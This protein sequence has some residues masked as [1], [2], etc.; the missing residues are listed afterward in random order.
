[1][2]DRYFAARRAPSFRK[3]SRQDR[4]NGFS[5]RLIGKRCPGNAGGNIQW[6]I[7]RI[8]KT[9]GQNHPRFLRDKRGGA[10]IRMAA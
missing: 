9:V 1:M 4:L 8:A 7:E 10:I 5:Q 3:I 2:P 6:S